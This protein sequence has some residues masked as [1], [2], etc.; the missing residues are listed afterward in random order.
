MAGQEGEI[1]QVFQPPMKNTQGICG[2]MW[3]LVFY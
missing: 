1:E 3:A 2:L